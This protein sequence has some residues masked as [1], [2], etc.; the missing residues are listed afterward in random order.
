MNRIKIEREVDGFKFMA[1]ATYDKDRDEWTC[2]IA[3][4]TGRRPSTFKG[5]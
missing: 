5:K 2:R 4:I 1:V 3:D